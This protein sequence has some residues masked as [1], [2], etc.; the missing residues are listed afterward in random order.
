MSKLTHGS[1]FSGIGGFELAARWAGIETLWQIEYNEYC[2]KILDR[3]FPNSKK[4]KDIKEVNPNELETVDI[5]SGGFPCQPFSFAGKRRGKTDD[6]YLWPK[7][8]EIIRTVKSSYV[9]CENV[10]GIIDM[11]LDQTLADL[12]DLNYSC[13]TFI[14][15]ACA[16]DAPHRRDRVWIIAYTTSQYGDSAKFQAQISSKEIEKAIRNWQN[17]W[18]IHRGVNHVEFRKTDELLLCRNTNGLPNELDRLKALG[19]AIV[20]QIAHLFFTAIK[21]NR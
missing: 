3:H 18:F 4:F 17:I 15:P 12:E 16:L 9:L 5:I 13:E 20:P 6:R 8:L 10:F 2:R 11:A 21:D 14:I 19:N 7:M 1:C